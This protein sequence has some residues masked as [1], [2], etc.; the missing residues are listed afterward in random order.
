[1]AGMI[2]CAE[3]PAA[4]AGIEMLRKGGNAVD[5]AIA[6][7]FAEGVT[8]PI[9]CGIGGS[10]TMMLHLAASGE[11][12][13]LDFWGVC[14]SGGDL[15][16]LADSYLG[17]DGACT[18]YHVRGRTTEVGH[19]ASLV[20]GFV[21]GTHTA[22]QRFGSGKLAWGD[23]LEPAI[24]LA[25][26]GFEVYP[27]IYQ[28]W[29]RGGSF[30]GHDIFGRLSANP[31][32]AAIYTNDGRPWEV[33]ERFVQRELARTL[34]RIAHDGADVF[35]HGEIGAAIARDFEA[36]G[37]YI[38]K[39]D[40]EEYE[41]V[42]NPPVRGGYR[43]MEVVSD[44]APGSGTLVVEILQAAEAFRIGSL[45]W[46]SPEYVD[47]LGRIFTLVF[48]DRARYMGDPR[49]VD[50]PVAMLTGREHTDAI[51]EKVRTDADLD[52]PTWHPVGGTGTTHVSVVD[53]DGNVAGMTHTLGTCSGIVTPGLGFLYNNDMHA[54]D[55][56]PGDPNSIAPGKRAVNGGGPTIL[57]RDGRPVLIVGSP[58]GARKVTA[59]CQAILNVYE[60]GMSIQGAVSTPRFH[61]EDQRRLIVLEP[62]FPRGTAEGLERLGCRVQRDAYGARL[63]AILR[64][65]SS[66]ALEGGA[67]PRGGGGLAEL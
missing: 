38:R 2:V 60:H 46:N 5:A 32:A 18:R 28:I 7:G 3:P 49:F 9:M 65:P 40:L 4:Q 15:K 34:E 52:E 63:S 11:Q 59:I 54:F 48:A 23:L 43:D 29:R 33:G 36:N 21:R 31:A 58:A 17:Q 13:A 53:P 57:L 61:A 30:S 27:Y 8:N 24:R 22:W 56:V 66:G 16:A 41:P 25:R 47:R 20:P 6:A 51:A 14:G 12:V 10:G 67:D 50:V 37:G 1:M 19:S 44:H 64:D 45:P 35:Y 42:F 55:P 39:R 26:D 62:T